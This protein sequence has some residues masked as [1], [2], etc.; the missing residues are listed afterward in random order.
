MGFPTWPTLAIKKLAVKERLKDL[1]IKIP[2]LQ[3]CSLLNPLL[4]RFH[5]IIWDINI[6]RQE[7]ICFIFNH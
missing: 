4:V 2:P 6:S 5:Y 1:I 7:Q 3:G